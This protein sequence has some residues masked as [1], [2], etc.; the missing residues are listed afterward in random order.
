MGNKIRGIKNSIR[1]KFRPLTANVAAIER[2]ARMQEKKVRESYAIKE[3]CENLNENEIKKLYKLRQ[4]LFLRRK[5]QTAYQLD[6]TINEALI[7]YAWHVWR[8]KLRYA[9]QENL[10][11]FKADNM[12]APL[13]KKY[14]TK[15]KMASFGK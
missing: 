5:K 6:E 12:L 3:P 4:L 2:L 1:K 10:P 13:Y 14:D 11:D 7:K 8:N 15:R 9:N